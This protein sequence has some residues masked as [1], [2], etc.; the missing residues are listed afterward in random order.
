[1]KPGQLGAFLKQ[2]L[3]LAYSLGKEAEVVGMRVTEHIE[4]ICKNYVKL[5][6]GCCCCV[7]TELPLLMLVYEHRFAAVVAVVWA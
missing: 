2:S 3:K 7:G 4:D 1:M 6:K 5:E